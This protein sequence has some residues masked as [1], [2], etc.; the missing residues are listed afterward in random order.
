MRRRTRMQSPSFRSDNRKS[1]TCPEPFD[2]T[3]DKLRPRIQNLKWGG[4]VAI[5]IVF[6]MYGVVA[7]A[8]QPKKVPR[9]GYLSNSDPV[10]ESARAEAVR[11]ALRS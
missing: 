7:E 8:Q 9:L 3:Q 4:L 1:K 2:S 10:T 6:A 5:G 11:L